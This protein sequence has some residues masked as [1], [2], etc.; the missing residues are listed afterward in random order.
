VEVL[1]REFVAERCFRIDNQSPGA[2]L[3]PIELSS[4]LALTWHSPSEGSPGATP[5]DEATLA[6]DQ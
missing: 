1:E 2:K 4:A 5:L 3:L 6:G